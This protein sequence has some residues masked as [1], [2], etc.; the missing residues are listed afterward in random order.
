LN[1]VRRD[2]L[3][4][5]NLRSVAVGADRFANRS[6]G[7]TFRGDLADVRPSGRGDA[8]VNARA[9]EALSG[10][11]ARAVEGGYAD[12]GRRLSA[13]EIRSSGGRGDGTSMTGAGSRV[14]RDGASARSEGAGRSVTGRTQDSGVGIDSRSG[15][16]GRTG[17]GEA[18]TIR[19]YP[20]QGARGTS[21][22]TVRRNEGS[23]SSSSSSF[24]SRPGVS[25]GSARVRE[26]GSGSSSGSTANTAMNRPGPSGPILPAARPR[27]APG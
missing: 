19:S 12:N 24:G 18:R 7:I 9:A 3:Q 27:G 21:S 11:N 6:D 10:R 22:G 8:T 13:G 4:D 26:T 14:I 25:S 15:S 5:R 17:A 20:S 2:Q 16:A 23:A 1:V